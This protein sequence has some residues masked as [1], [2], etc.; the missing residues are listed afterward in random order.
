MLNGCFKGPRIFVAIIC[1]HQISGPSAIHKLV[2]EIQAMTIQQELGKNASGLATKIHHVCK[3]I[4]GIVKATNVPN[5][6]PEVCTKKG[7]S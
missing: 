3:H 7:H 1:Q 5:D 2:S 6:L 4:T